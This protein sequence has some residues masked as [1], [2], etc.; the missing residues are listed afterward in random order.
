MTN[1][2]EEISCEYAGVG[3]RWA[4]VIDPL[5]VAGHRRQDPVLRMSGRDGHPGFVL[6]IDVSTFRLCPP[7]VD[8]AAIILSDLKRS[9]AVMI[10]ERSDERMRSYIAA[11]DQGRAS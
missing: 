4:I 9:G 7:S 3:G 2:N 1:E 8:R 10:V 11:V 5:P 6:H